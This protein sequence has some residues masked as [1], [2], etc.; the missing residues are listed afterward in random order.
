MPKTLT[1]PTRT[2]RRAVPAPESSGSHVA[3]TTPEPNLA[4][5]VAPRV[6]RGPDDSARRDFAEPSLRVTAIPLAIA[7]ITLLALLWLYAGWRR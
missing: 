2:G 7:C 5:V 1:G 4:A 3:I 6:H